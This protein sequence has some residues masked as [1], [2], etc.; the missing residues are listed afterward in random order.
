MVAYSTTP[1]GYLGGGPAVS[2]S[3]HADTAASSNSPPDPD[4]PALD[5]HLVL[6]ADEREGQTRPKLG[7]VCDGCCVVFHIVRK[8]P[9][10]DLVVLD[11]FHDAALEVAQ[12]GRGAG[13]GPADD[14]RAPQKRERVSCMQSERFP[15]VTTCL[16]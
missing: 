7:V 6:A 11:V 13:V 5:D 3:V 8:V 9:N 12:L 16:G 10:G 15:S 4:E 14:W 2:L 1:Q